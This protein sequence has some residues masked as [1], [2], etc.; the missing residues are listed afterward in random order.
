MRASPPKDRV[1]GMLRDGTWV[2]FRPIRPRDKAALKR[3]MAMLSPESRYHRFFAAI[4]SLSSAQLK[5][6]TEIDYNDHFA[7]F[8]VLPDTHPPTGI[9]VARYIRLPNDP[10]SAEAAVTVVDDYHRHGVGTALLRLL[11]GTAIEHG[12]KRFVLAVMGENE[13]MLHLLQ[14]T[15]AVVDS[16]EDGIAQVHVD[17]PA[18]AEELAKTPAPE[19]LR[20]TAEGRLK[21]RAGPRGV[22]TRF[23]GD[24][25]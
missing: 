22:G 3:G 5:Y 1:D 16:W 12:I 20:H 21:G 8:A 7:W 24:D 17:L 11:A 10:E 18:T 6:F 19:I 9:G 25:S 15:G 4:D 2:I 13:P 23:T 14:A